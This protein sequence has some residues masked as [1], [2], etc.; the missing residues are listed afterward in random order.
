MK[1]SPLLAPLLAL[2]VAA[3]AACHS[4]P[5][6]ITEGPVYP[7][8]IERGP[9][10]NIQVFRGTTQLEFTNTTARSI[11]PC[12]L[13]LNAWFSV[14]LNGLEV[15]Q[16]LR[17]PLRDCRDRYGVSFRGGGFFATEL[18]ERLAL[19][20]LQ[21]DNKLLGLVVVGGDSN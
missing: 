20:E 12:R 15:G 21:L 17:L 18:P 16:T 4:A 7:D 6:T 9:T 11:P 13:W 3:L 10:L 2:L 5:S 19:A 1:R 8:K 14:D